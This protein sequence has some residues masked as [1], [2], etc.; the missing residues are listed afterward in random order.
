[1]PW[2]GLLATLAWN[3]TRHL[4]GRS[5]ICGLFRAHV[6]R[7]LVVPLWSGL[8]AWILPHLWRGYEVESAHTAAPAEVVE[9]LNRGLT[10]T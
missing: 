5:T 4:R 8:T 2:V 7:V 3:Y 1:M 10:N 6:P 9:H